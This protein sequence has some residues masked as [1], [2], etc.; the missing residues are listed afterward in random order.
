MMSCFALHENAR[1]ALRLSAEAWD[2]INN[3]EENDKEKKRTTELIHGTNVAL[4]EQVD[5][6]PVPFGF[7]FSFS[8]SF[9]FSFLFFLTLV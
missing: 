7:A 2:G 6:S 3:N 8:F 1:D 4:W 9:F 5:V